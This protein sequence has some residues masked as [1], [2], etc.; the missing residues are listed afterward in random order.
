MNEQSTFLTKATDMLSGLW[1]PELSAVESKRTHFS[2]E[3]TL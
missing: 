1:K 2:N 3:S